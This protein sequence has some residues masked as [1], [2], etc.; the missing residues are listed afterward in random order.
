MVNSSGKT[1]KENMFSTLTLLPQDP[2][3]GMQATYKADDRG[4]KINLSIG[5]CL[6]ESGKLL[7]FKALQEANQRVQQISPSKEY[8]PITGLAVYCEEAQRLV[9]GSIDSKE[10]F[11]AQTVGG[12]GALYVAAQLLLKAGVKEVYIPEPTWPNHKQLFQAAGFIVKSYPYYDRANI[13][14]EF[15]NMCAAIEQMPE[16]AAII[17]Q[18]SC[19]NPTGIDPTREQW[20]ALSPLIKKKKLFPIFDLA[21]VGLGGTIEEDTQG[22]RQFLHDEHDLFICTT[23]AK[24]MGLYNDRLGLLTVKSK[25]TNL[26]ILASHIRS[27]IRTCY[28]SPPAYGAYLAKEVLVDAQLRT[29]WLNELAATRQRL[30]GQRKALYTHLQKHHCKIPYEHILKTKGLFC[31][32]D[33]TPDEVIKLRDKTG[34]YIALDGRISLAAITQDNVDAIGQGLALL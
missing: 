6:D 9:V 31:L 25:K 34:I 24:S 4:N 10:L 21:Y 22:I 13:R 5:I 27:I 17:L 3:Y 33:I 29:Q 18:A 14:L 19:H 28:S 15:E 8:L 11:S 20:Q 1:S 23:F 2:I 26:D 30:E 12:T 7:R 16:G 32:L